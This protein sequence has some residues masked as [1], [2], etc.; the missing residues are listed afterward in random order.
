MLKIHKTHSKLKGE[1]EIERW[2]VKKEKEE[3]RS[4]VSDSQGATHSTSLISKKIVWHPNL[5]YNN[6]N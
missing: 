2:I 1:T 6:I 3:A 4:Q 5:H